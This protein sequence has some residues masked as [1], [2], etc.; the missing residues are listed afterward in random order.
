VRAAA[1][2]HRPAWHRTVKTSDRTPS[3]HPDERGRA[4]PLDEAFLRSYDELRA[5]ADQL[6][7]RRLGH[8]MQ[9]T[10]LVHETWLRLARRGG[11]A[12]PLRGDEHLMALA[13]RAMR[14]VLVD[15]ARRR[16]ARKREGLRAPEPPDGLAC[17]DPLPGLDCVALHEALER[18]AEIDE[19]KARVVELR[20]FGG[21]EVE[22]VAEVLAISPATVK[23]DWP[24]AKAWLWRELGG[25]ERRP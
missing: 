9:T 10:S 11:P 24:L 8:R 18:L 17:P 13:A 7:R 16:T 2:D 15:H 19:R 21:L 25:R 12:A 14:T 1:R 4:A 3:T 6:L 22:E 23:R 20:F 5:L